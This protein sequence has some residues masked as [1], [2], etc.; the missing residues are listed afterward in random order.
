VD[1][2]AD[3][4]C[5]IYSTLASVRLSQARPQ[6]AHQALQKSYS[7]WADLPPDSPLIPDY[8]ARLNL[9]R[10]FIECEDLPS[11][12]DILDGLEDENDEELEMLYLLALVNFMQGEKEKDV[13]TQKTNFIDARETLE[14][15]LQVASRKPQGEI[16]PEL[17][18]QINEMVGKIEKDRGITMK[19]V[20]EANQL[21]AARQAE[22]DGEDTEWVDED[23]EMA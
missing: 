15:F 18:E 17:T 19:Q 20:E 23:E 10:L 7:I 6:E 16:N 5:E 13:E 8:E 22:E 12:L 14:K 1:A 2:G 3:L 21:A 11:A 9:V 4:N